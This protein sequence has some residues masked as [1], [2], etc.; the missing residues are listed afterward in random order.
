VSYTVGEV[1]RLSGKRF[2]CVDPENGTTLCQWVGVE[3]LRLSDFG[4]HVAISGAKRMNE[5]CFI[6]EAV[7]STDRFE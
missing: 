1:D 2:P 3:L 7:Q 5:T 6:P 4:L